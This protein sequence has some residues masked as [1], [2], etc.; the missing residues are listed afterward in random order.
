MV[1]LQLPLALKNPHPRDAHV[2]FDEER[3][4]YHVTLGGVTV[5]APTSATKFAERYFSTF[6]ANKVVECNY[7]KWKTNS[8]SKYY[9]L[10]HGCLLAGATDEDA[11]L[12]IKEGW[13]QKGVEAA[14]QGTLVHSQCELVCN[15]LPVVK[16]SKEIEQ[17]MSWIEGWQ[18]AM[19]W[20]PYRTEM[21]L[22]FDTKG[23]VV[24][25]GS[26]DLILKSAVTGEF[27]LVDFKV[28]PAL[29]GPA[30]GFHPGFAASPMHTFEDS[31]FGRYEAQLNILSHILRNKYDINVGK[32]MYLLQLHDTLQS[33]HCV[34]VSDREDEVETLFAVETQRL[35]LAQTAPVL[36]HA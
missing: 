28:S 8:T 2:S 5:T 11:K 1:S 12:A 32:H 18:P 33:W 7:H 13:T 9:S 4:E 21:R 16:S 23:V 20:A 35:M 26:P 24:L 31:K 15:A 6:D 19:Q 34:Q 36:S 27:A 17:L 25:A 30:N 29:I 14:A 22:Y 10:I 3:H